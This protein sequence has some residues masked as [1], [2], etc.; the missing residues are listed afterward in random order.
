MSLQSQV[1]YWI[2]CDRCGGHEPDMQEQESE[3]YA[4]KDF[5]WRPDDSGHDICTSCRRIECGAC[6]ECDACSHHQIMTEHFKRA[7]GK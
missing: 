1:M 6:G 3:Y 2:Q 5:G 4:R 7:M